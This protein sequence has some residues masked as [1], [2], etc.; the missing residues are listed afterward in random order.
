MR[1]HIIGRMAALWTRFMA[2]SSLIGQFATLSSPIGCPTC[3][4]WGEWLQQTSPAWDWIVTRGCC[5]LVQLSSSG[6]DP[7]TRH[8]TQ[9]QQ[10]STAATT[11]SEFVAIYGICP[12]SIPS[13][14]F[15]TSENKLLISRF[16]MIRWTFWEVNNYYWYWIDNLHYIS[17]CFS[18]S[19]SVGD[20]G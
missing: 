3:L 12:P 2:V 9:H 15:W 17:V 14:K 7:D 18:S 10:M 6:P 5:W 13:L 1:G 16:K 20:N 4:V 19:S 8:C 11:G